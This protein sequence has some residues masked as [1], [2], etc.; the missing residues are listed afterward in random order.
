MNESRWWSTHVKPRWHAPKSGRVAWKVQDAF[1]AGLPD[2]DA[3]FN[4]KACKI[5]LKYEP[6]PP[7]HSTTPLWFSTV[8]KVLKRRAIV[9][10][11]QWNY[12]KEWHDAGGL[13]F[14]LIGVKQTWYLLKQGG[15]ENQPMTIEELETC[16]ECWGEG[17][18]DLAVIP[19]FIEGT[20]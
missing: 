18:A 15:Y 7:V 11:A 6:N 4:G 13:A 12:L 14:V 19:S 3:C 10:G 5:E 17:Y 8:D 9:S 1:N 20:Y 16:C 2:V